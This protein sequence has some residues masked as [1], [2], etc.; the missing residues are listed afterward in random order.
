MS[1]LIWNGTIM[2]AM[3]FPPDSLLTGIILVLVPWRF[4]K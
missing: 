3:Q 4:L 1:V 2:Y